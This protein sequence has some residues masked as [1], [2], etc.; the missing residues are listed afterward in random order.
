[1]CQGLGSILRIT[2][3]VSLLRPTPSPNPHLPLFSAPL[4]GLRETKGRHSSK[5]LKGFVFGQISI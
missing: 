4:L 5:L 1:M 2:D 3:I